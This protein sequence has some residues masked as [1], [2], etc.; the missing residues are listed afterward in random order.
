MIDEAPLS[1]SKGAEVGI[2]LIGGGLH[3]VLV[4]IAK[5]VPRTALGASK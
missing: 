3:P 2:M 1:V 4:A 5:Y